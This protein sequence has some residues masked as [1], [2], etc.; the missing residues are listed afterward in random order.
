MHSKYESAFS[1][2]DYVHVR[3]NQDC[4]VSRQDTNPYQLIATPIWVLRLLLHRDVRQTKW[5]LGACRSII[6]SS[7]SDITDVTNTASTINSRAATLTKLSTRLHAFCT[8]FP[9]FRH[10]S[11]LDFSHI[12]MPHSKTPGQ[13]NAASDKF[14]K[15]QAEDTLLAELFPNVSM[16]RRWLSSR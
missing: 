6:A 12:T 7:I 13:S 16:F 15:Q 9:T 11:I 14:N 5:T 4:D 3:S 10:R 8:R 1:F 2:S